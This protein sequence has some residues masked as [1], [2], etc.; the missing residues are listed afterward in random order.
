MTA[1]MSFIDGPAC[2]YCGST[3]EERVQG[4]ADPLHFYECVD[5][6][7]CTK[8]CIAAKHRKWRE[9]QGPQVC[10]CGETMRLANDGWHCDQPD[11]AA[12]SALI[13]VEGPT[14]AIESLPE[15][16]PTESN[17]STKKCDTCRRLQEKL[18][19]NAEECTKEIEKLRRFETYVCQVIA[20]GNQADLTVEALPK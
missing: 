9:D 2:D 20:M 10:Q 1:S 6:N 7:A 13:I 8:R 12:P 14:E 19:L 18:D 3:T 17:M 5:A 16:I 4:M 15:F 11:C